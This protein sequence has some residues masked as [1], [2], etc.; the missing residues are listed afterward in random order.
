LNETHKRNGKTPDK[1]IGAEHL[2]NNTLEPLTPRTH[3]SNTLDPLNPRTLE[4]SLPAPAITVKNL[5]M[6]YGMN[7]IQRDLTFTVN[8]GDVFIIMGGSGC[9]KSTLL[10]HLIG[11]IE[12]AIGQIFYG[13]VNFWEMEDATI[14]NP[15]PERCPLELNDPG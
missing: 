14:W 10:K 15:L 1:V 13:N 7:V 6:A 3:D 11:L 5:T 8:R 2:K 4:P 9:G 12:P